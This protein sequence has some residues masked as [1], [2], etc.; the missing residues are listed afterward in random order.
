M[1]IVNSNFKKAFCVHFYPSLLQLQHVTSG[2]T[3][4]SQG[5]TNPSCC[6]VAWLSKLSGEPGEI[7]QSAQVIPSPAKLVQ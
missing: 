2:V 7:F 4:F 1:G 3:H 6:S 5:E